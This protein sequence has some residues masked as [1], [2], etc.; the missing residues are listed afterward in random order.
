MGSRPLLAEPRRPGVGTRGPAQPEVDGDPNPPIHMPVPRG[1]AASF[2][3]DPIPS[4]H[5]PACLV[6]QHGSKQP[7]PSTCVGRRSCWVG[8]ARAGSMD[9]EYRDCR[10][11]LVSTYPM[12]TI[13]LAIFMA[14]R[15]HHGWVTRSPQPFEVISRPFGPNSDGHPARP[16]SDIQPRELGT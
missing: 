16:A 2:F 1:P 5:R 4:Q 12:L 13:H 11:I 15:V 9:A 6:G 14:R 10:A 3:F 7:Y 8:R